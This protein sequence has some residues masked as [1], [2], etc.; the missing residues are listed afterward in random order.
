MPTQQRLAEFVETVVSGRY[1]DA[2]REFYADT[3]EVRENEA[4]P[5]IGLEQL[6]SHERAFLSTVKEMRTRAAHQ[7]LLNADTVAIHWEFEMTYPDGV[8]RLFSEV[9]LQRWNDRHIVHEQYFYDP[10][11]LRR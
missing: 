4:V 7:V 11:Q 9:A 5:R 6:I 2:L 8:A 3:A 1:I 10:G